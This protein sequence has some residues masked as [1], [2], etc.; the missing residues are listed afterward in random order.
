MKL[1]Q[2]VTSLEI[3]KKLKELGIKQKSLFSYCQHIDNPDGGEFF[4]LEL[5]E[6]DCDLSVDGVSAFTA[7]ELGEIL[8][9]MINNQK[10]FLYVWKDDADRWRVDYTQWGMQKMAY[11]IEKEDTL[12]NAMGKMLIYLLENNLL[13][14]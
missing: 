1:E 12:A 10:D 3:S 9:A 13:T 14:L 2:Q 8:P 7:A 5:S 4:Q 6:D 11:M